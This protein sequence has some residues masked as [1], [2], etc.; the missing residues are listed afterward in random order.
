MKVHTCMC[1]AI[2]LQIICLLPLGVTVLATVLDIVVAEAVIAVVAIVIA[3]VAMLDDET[4]IQ[5]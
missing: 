3:V 2:H 1:D 5:E 4:K